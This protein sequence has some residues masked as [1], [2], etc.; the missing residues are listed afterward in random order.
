MATDW[1]FRTAT[2]ADL[3]FLL[4]L[5]LA[6]MTP[7]FAR[8]GIVLSDD[9]HWQRA[10]FR[11]DAAR[12]ITHDGA[13]IGLLK[14]LRDDGVWTV[15]QFQVAPE[16]QGAGVGAGVLREVIDEARAAGV[17]LRLSV[18]KE[19]PAR[20]LYARLGF[21]TLGESDN[22]FKMTFVDRDAASAAPG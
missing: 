16:F 3:P 4:A 12:I 9:E 13:A 2:D 17:T 19:N 7:Q 10:E 22:S 18:L 6:T 5:R 15:E 11:L 21:V 20:H 14:L 1:A 8:Q